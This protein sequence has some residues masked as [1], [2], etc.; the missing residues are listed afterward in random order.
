MWVSE[1][2]RWIATADGL[3]L[4]SRSLHPSHLRM[5]NTRR[6]NNLRSAPRQSTCKRTR[7]FRSN[8]PPSRNPPGTHR[9]NHRWGSSGCSKGVPRRKRDRPVRSWVSKAPRQTPGRFQSPSRARMTFAERVASTC[10]LIYRCFK[11]KKSL[12]ASDRRLANLPGN[13]ERDD[14]NA[15]SVR[16]GV[17]SSHELSWFAFRMNPNR[18]GGFGKRLNCDG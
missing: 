15:R 10:L 9:Y 12:A 5:D 1:E 7:T 13:S 18:K 16:V 14:R 17:H 8:N 2:S 11:A 6:S 3:I 4:R